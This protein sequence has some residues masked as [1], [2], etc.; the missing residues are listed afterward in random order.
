MLS[1]ALSMFHIGIIF[2]FSTSSLEDEDLKMG[3]SL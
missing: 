1:Y 2:T 3:N